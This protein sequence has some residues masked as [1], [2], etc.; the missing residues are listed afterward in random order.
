M[1]PYQDTADSTAGLTPF[2]IGWAEGP[3]I[4]DALPSEL[5]TYLAAVHPDD[6]M[7]LERAARAA[8]ATHGPFAIPHRVV[9]DRVRQMLW[10][11][12]ADVDG[13]TVR[14]AGYRVDL[15]EAHDEAVASYIAQSVRAS[16]EHRASIERA[17]GIVMAEHG[18]DENDAFTA[19]RHR[20]NEANVKLRLLAQLIVQERSSRGLIDLDRSRRG[21]I[22]SQRRASEGA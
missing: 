1:T 21:G 15:T 12:T 11:G 19:L 20:S 17:K 5:V 4:D 7:V 18:T 16:E 9:A 6:R 14:L 10:G 13:D 2:S 3:D 22:T 8:A